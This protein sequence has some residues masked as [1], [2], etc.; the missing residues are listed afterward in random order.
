MSRRR[1]YSSNL[2]LVRVH[3]APV[4]DGVKDA[5]LGSTSP[6]E[7]LHDAGAGIEDVLEG[8]NRLVVGL[9]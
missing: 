7:Y 6:Q 8:N 4:E 9:V 5:D 2:V 1:E 3:F